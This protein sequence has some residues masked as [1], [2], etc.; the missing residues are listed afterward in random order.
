MK[1]QGIAT[2]ELKGLKV[3]FLKPAEISF[4][5]DFSP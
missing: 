1:K 5:A 4:S 2:Y 3:R